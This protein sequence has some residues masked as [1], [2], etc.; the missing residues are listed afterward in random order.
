MNLVD[1]QRRC[2]RCL[3]DENDEQIGRDG[4]AEIVR[5]VRLK[6]F[7]FHYTGGE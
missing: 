3:N 7:V 2:C 6:V 5:L 4:E 1:Q